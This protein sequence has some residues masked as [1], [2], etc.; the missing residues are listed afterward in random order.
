MFIYLVDRLWTAT[1]VCIAGISVVYSLR[2]YTG[3]LFS[4][5]IFATIVL[6]YIQISTVAIT[7]E[8]QLR[9]LG[10]RA[11]SQR[12][13]SPYNFGILIEAVSYVLQHRN[14]VFWW[15]LFENQ[16]NPARPWTVESITAGERIIFTAD[17]D[18]IKA[19]LATQF[20]EYGKGPRFRVEWKDFLGL[21]I[22]T[23]D[24]DL[25]HNS[26]S[27][28]R[29]QFIKDR[30]SDLHTF[31]KHTQV[32]I[33]LLGGKTDGATVQAD[34]LYYRFTLDAATDF[35]LGKSVDSL[36]NGQTE[37]AQ[38]FAQVQNTQSIIAR[39]GPLQ[40]LV[41]KAK[42]H[43]GLKV[44]NRFVG[45]YIDRALELPQEE[46]EKKTK[47]DEGYTFLHAI[48]SY[49]RDR[50]V[51]RD[52]L[53]AV[54]LAGRDTTA[55]TLSW[56][57]YELSRNPQVVQK[58]RQE[59]ISTVG[60]EDVPTYDNL[61]NMRYLQH[62][63]NEI[64]RLYPVVP[65][66]VR[67]ALQDTTLPRGG[68][69][70]GDEPVAIL[71][72]TPIGYSTLILQRRED[73]YPP[74]A[75]GFAPYLDFVPERW[76]HWTPKSWTYIPFNGGPRICIGQQ[77]ALTELAYTVVRILQTFDRIE[78]RMDEAPLL[79]TDIVLQPAKGVHVAFLGG[80]KQ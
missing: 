30:V 27:L 77:F 14:H 67:V 34:D 2:R 70:N 66:N 55:V 11:P 1:V 32:L 9:R 26:R 42:F 51:L 13:W 52:Q 29:P 15:R 69:K 61:K 39:T 72:D 45:T 60:L 79:R 40:H 68:G 12:G 6:Y 50:E 10:K 41:P 23:T 38:A 3:A 57:T 28:L 8:L 73:I 18:N 36:I 56:L 76:D 16:G 53:V 22:F 37:F 74:A 63:L 43:A 65:Y 19:I 7:Y 31:E 35:L 59:I 78:C 21:S 25:W 62:T 46:L 64:L 48:A 33:R 75:S 71:K 58:L 47:S 80:K 17:E 24:G 44:V 49:T 54:L 4:Y 5:A 20:A